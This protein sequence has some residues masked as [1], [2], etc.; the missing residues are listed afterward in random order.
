MPASACRPTSGATRRERCR[1]QREFVVI[2][3]I[4]GQIIGAFDLA[5]SAKPG[6]DG[7]SMIG[8][9][10]SMPGILE[11]RPYLHSH[12]LAVL[13]D[14]R[15]SGIGR[16]LKLAQ[17]RRGALPRGIT[18]MEWTFDPTGAQERLPQYCS[19]RGHCSQLYP[20]LLWVYSLVGC[21]LACPPTGCMP[22]GLW[23]RRGS[24]QRSTA[25]RC[26]CLRLKRRSLSPELSG[27]GSS[28]RL[29]SPRPRRRK[30][31]VR[32]TFSRCL[33]SARLGRS[34]SSV[35]EPTG[36]SL[37]ESGSITDQ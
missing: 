13:P 27:S 34:P 17:R 23:T 12:M 31:E 30:A 25:A 29:A 7:P 10:M 15:N 16:K 22:N 36:T 14:Y 11:G 32:T 33:R 35:R 1:P 20:E 5:K 21:K 8:F 4:G 3:R 9:A 19:P 37:K 24:S 18:K 26:T 6:G 28:L 2:E